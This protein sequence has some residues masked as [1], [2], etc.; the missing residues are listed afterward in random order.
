VY[1]PRAGQFYA[2]GPSWPDE[3][4]QWRSDPTHVIG[5][6]PAGWGVTLARKP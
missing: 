2:H 3:V 4:A 5:T 6:W 1:Y